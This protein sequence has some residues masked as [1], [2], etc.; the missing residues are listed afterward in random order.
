MDT[1]AP[2]PAQFTARLA[3][4]RRKGKSPCGMFGFAVTTCD[5]N[6]PHTVAWEARWATLFAKLL[7]GVLKLGTEFNG[8]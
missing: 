5:G 4:M 2:E 6:L 3:E 8:V 7:Q 1:S